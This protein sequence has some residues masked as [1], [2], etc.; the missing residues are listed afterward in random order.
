MVTKGFG[1]KHIV[2]FAVI[3]AAITLYA[4]FGERGFVDVYRVKAER[5]S[6]AAR[7]LSLAAENKRLSREIELLK[8]DYRYI[9]SVARKELGMVGRDEVIYK[10][11]RTPARQ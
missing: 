11:E 6:L 9:A 1:K 5:D 4:V 10:I 7:N 8:S 3:L 2:T